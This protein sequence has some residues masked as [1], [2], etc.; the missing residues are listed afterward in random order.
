MCRLQHVAVALH[1]MYYSNVFNV[2][3]CKIY[4]LQKAAKRKHGYISKVRPVI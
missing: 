4:Y 1:S 2:S 3:G